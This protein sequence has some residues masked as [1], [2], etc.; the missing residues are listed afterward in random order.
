MTKIKKLVICFIGISIVGCLFITSVNL[1]VYISTK[2]QISKHIENADCILVLG[3][4]IRN[5]QPTPMLQDRLDEAISLYQQ[6]KAPKLIMS[7][8][9]SRNDYNE[10]AVMKNYAIEK[11]VS[12]TDIFM[13]H[14]G[15]S[16][17]ESIFRAKEIFQAKKVIIVTQDYH[18]YR[19]LYIANQ[20]GLEAVGYASN[21]REYRGQVKRDIREIAARCKDFMSCIYKPNPT[22]LGDTIP[23]SGDGNIT[24]DI[25]F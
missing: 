11:G 20:L 23:I 13:D 18:L 12:S 8:D 19:A 16:T 9:H 6:K 10:V 5:N 14:A 24:N 15:F 17:Y 3:A 21:P 22:Y 2:N 7:G 1:Y 4:G 25:I